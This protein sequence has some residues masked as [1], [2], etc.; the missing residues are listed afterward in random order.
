MRFD[1]Q[2]VH[3]LDLDRRVSSYGSE[4]ARSLRGRSLLIESV[5]AGIGANSKY[6][7]YPWD[8]GFLS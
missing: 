3:V 8:L 4:G 6:D 2:R 5:S 1:Q 7:A